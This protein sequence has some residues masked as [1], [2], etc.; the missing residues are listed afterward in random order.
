MNKDYTLNYITYIVHRVYIDRLYHSFILNCWR[1][2]ECSHQDVSQAIYNICVICVRAVLNVEALAFGSSLYIRYDMAADIV[3]STLNIII[4][5][6]YAN[7]PLNSIRVLSPAWDR[8]YNSFPTLALVLKLNQPYE[9]HLHN[10]KKIKSKICFKIWSPCWLVVLHECTVSKT[11]PQSI[12]TAYTT[13]L[14]NKRQD[15]DIV[16]HKKTCIQVY[17]NGAIQLIKWFAYLHLAGSL[18]PV[19][20]ERK[21]ALIPQRRIVKPGWNED[22]SA[23]ELTVTWAWLAVLNAFPTL[24]CILLKLKHSFNIH[25]TFILFI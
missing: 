4:T 11:F 3:N 19:E 2:Y 23:W 12:F 9:S 10:M 24:S 7:I 13:K 14:E 25:Q 20:I 22:E 21:H 8:N 15:T 5:K 1:I 16:R 18:C 6:L 17:W